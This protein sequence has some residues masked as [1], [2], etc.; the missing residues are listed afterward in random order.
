MFD[1]SI[2]FELSCSFNCTTF[3]G[4]TAAV[5][6][7]A[8][9]SGGEEA[10]KSL[11][12]HALYTYATAPA[13][14]TRQQILRLG[15]MLMPSTLADLP[16]KLDGASHSQQLEVLCAL[17]QQVHCTG[18]DKDMD[19]NSDPLTDLLLRNSLLYEENVALKEQLSARRDRIHVQQLDL[20]HDA[21]V[22]QLYENLAALQK[23]QESLK[24]R[25]PT[26]S[27]ELVTPLRPMNASNSL[28]TDTS[29]TFGSPASPNKALSDL[30]EMHARNVAELRAQLRELSLALQEEQKARIA[31]SQS[32]TKAL[33]EVSDLKQSIREYQG[34]LKEVEEERAVA[35]APAAEASPEMQSASCQTSD[36]LAPS[37]T[38]STSTDEAKVNLLQAQNEQLRVKL[39]DALALLKAKSAQ[40]ESLPRMQSSK[41]LGPTRRR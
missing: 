4:A 22:G 38:E 37:P 30:S 25:E 23:A 3:E 19:E 6:Q 12:V 32:Q 16:P 27:T 28:T 26:E 35:L 8:S 24:R 34:R 11:A 9:D 29:R 1:E 20:V 5:S 13:P 14:T 17:E 39:R 33:A 31:A 36:E 15:R 18:L 10:V 21:L 7:L 40:P 41:E 2:M